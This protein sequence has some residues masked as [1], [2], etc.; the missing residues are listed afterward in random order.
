MKLLLIID[1]AIEHSNK[2]IN[3]LL[4]YSREMHLDYEE[5][6]PK[7][8]ISYSLLTITVPSQIK[9]LEHVEDSPTI[10]VDTNKMQRVF[11]NLIKN[12]IDAMTNG[13]SLEISSRHNDRDC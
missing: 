7:S 6:S 9:I 8:L 1:R 4:D 12:A 5:C 10:W 3:D 13:G 11:T 2:I